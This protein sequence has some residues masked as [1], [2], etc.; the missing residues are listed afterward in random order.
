MKNSVNIIFCELT[1]EDQQF[2]WDMLYL[3]IYVHKGKE[4]YPREIVKVPEIAL[5]ASNWGRKHDYGLVAI[6]QETGN[7]IGLAWYR[8]FPS[9]S[10]GFG[11]V[12]KET[13][14]LAMSVLK[15]YQGK[16][17][18]TILL[19]E[20][21]DKAAEHYS[22][23]SLSVDLENYACKMYEKVGFTKVEI[24]NDSVTL[25]KNFV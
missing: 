7:K 12:N 5:Y 14:E 15:E 8:L 2:L 11:F 21:L 20:L 19:R 4:P 17:I 3:A 18:G 13:P 9:D 23:I 24:V 25:I 6:D 22:S 16:G 1:K 10:K